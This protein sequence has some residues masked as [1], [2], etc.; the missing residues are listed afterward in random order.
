MNDKD[1]YS[2]TVVYENKNARRN[3]FLFNFIGGTWMFSLIACYSVLKKT[4]K[5]FDQPAR[6]WIIAL[7][8]AIVFGLALGI[9]RVIVTK[10]IRIAISDTEVDVTVGGAH[11]TYLLENYIGYNRRMSDNRRTSMIRELKF[12]DPDSDE[13]ETLYIH[14]PHIS[15]VLFRDIVDAISI[16]QKAGSGEHEE[17]VPF[18]GDLF[19][20]N[21]EESTEKEM[22]KSL[23]YVAYGL[24]FLA[25]V[26]LIILTCLGTIRQGVGIFMSIVCG[27]VLVFAIV[28]YLYLSHYEKK[29]S[30]LQIRTISFHEAFLKINEKTYNFS[31]MTS[32][33]MTKPDAPEV[34]ED[35][36]RDLRFT[37]KNDKESVQFCFGLRPKTKASE[38]EPSDSDIYTYEAL[39]AR[40]RKICE[41]RNICF[42]VFR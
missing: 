6:R 27:S 30:W 31:E 23:L 2:G 11:G 21:E 14:L 18:E 1:L 34:I 3:G 4:D 41:E 12:R 8:I 17:Y 5:G 15:D 42:T 13:E 22:S 25:M 29:M 35:D 38:D 36:T 20:V 33:Y 19:K 16:K 24:L 7:G 9:Y 39:F 32:V 37:M 10:K 40:I 28:A 26:V